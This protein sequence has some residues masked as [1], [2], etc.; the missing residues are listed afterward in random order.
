MA[1]FFFLASH[2][3]GESAPQRPF[4]HTEIMFDDAEGDDDNHTSGCLF[5]SKFAHA[6]TRYAE[7]AGRRCNVGAVSS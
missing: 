4:S 7:G 5:G 3:A 1:L 6:H 2:D